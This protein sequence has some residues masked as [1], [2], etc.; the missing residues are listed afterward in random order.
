M[1][2]HRFDP[3]SLVFGALF[4]FLGLTFLGGGVDPA[5]IRLTWVWSIPVL[6]VGMLLVL[7]AVRHAVEQRE[8]HDAAEDPDP[9]PDPDP[10]APPPAGAS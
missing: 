2:R 8:G 10:V 6:V 7:Y 5:D 1:K 9:S 3:A 4:L